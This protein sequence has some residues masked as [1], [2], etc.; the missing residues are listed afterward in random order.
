M[1]QF[2]RSEETFFAR[3]NL[4]ELMRIFKYLGR[5][6]KRLYDDWPQPCGKL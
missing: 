5:V 2:R 1:D 4:L 3:I 6:V